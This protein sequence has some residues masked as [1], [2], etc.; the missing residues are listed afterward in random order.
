MLLKVCFLQDKHR[1]PTSLYKP[2]EKGLDPSQ[3]NNKICI[4]IC[5]KSNKIFKVFMYL[6]FFTISYLNQF[7]KKILSCPRKLLPRFLFKTSRMWG[8]QETLRESGESWESFPSLEGTYA[9]SCGSQT[10]WPSSLLEFREKPSI[11]R[12][13]LMAR[14]IFATIAGQPSD[15]SD[16]RQRK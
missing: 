13:Y 4:C 8:S 15:K 5:F 7:S 12:C 14:L 11:S 1:I 2:K 3:K 16:L 10:P 9:Q 6:F